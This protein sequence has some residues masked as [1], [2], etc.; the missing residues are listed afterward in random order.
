VVNRPTGSEQ[1]PVRRGRILDRQGHALALDI[2][3]YQITAT[4]RWISRPEEVEEVAH[5]LAPLLDLPL[6]ELITKLSSDA[7]WVLL[8]HHVSREVGETLREWDIHGVHVTPWPRRGYPEG[9]LAAHLMGFVA[10]DQQGFYG[11]EGYYH[12]LLSLSVGAEAK[13]AEPGTLASAVA[14]GAFPFSLAEITEEGSPNLILTMDRMIQHIA[15]EE[16]DA[17]IGQHQASGGTVIVMEPS[18]GA[19]LAMASRPVFEPEH[20]DEAPSAELWADPAVTLDYEPGSVFKIVTLAAAVD[21]GAITLDQV[22]DDKGMVEI[23]GQPIYNSDRLAHGRVTVTEAMALSLNTVLAEFSAE[24][25]ARTFYAYVQRFGFGRRTGVD[26]AGESEGQL[27][28]STD[29]TWHESD[30]G[31][32]AFG[33]GLTVTPLQMACAVAAIANRGTMM[34]PHVLKEIVSQDES[35]P[36]HPTVVRQVVSP[37][38]VEKLIPILIQATEKGAPKAVVPGY[39]IAGKSGTAE[40]PIPGGYDSRWTIASFIGFAPAHDPQFLILVKVDR[41]RDTPWGNAVAAPVFRNIAQRLFIMMHIP[42][43]RE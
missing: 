43:D 10:E 4:P 21:A 16:L 39:I 7:P 27:R 31:T 15:E 37:E 22:F 5:R 33:Q 6:E 34:T 26:L 30:L 1:V 36:R 12:Q 14:T 2:I 29:A 42:P 3:E 18:S 32:N 23:G 19:I 20:F 28:L 13:E 9:T 41:P 25:G 8:R 38:T 17:A 11:V 40:I 24:L 35:W